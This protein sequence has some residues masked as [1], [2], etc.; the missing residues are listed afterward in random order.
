MDGHEND[1]VKIHG[2][3]FVLLKKFIDGQ[4]SYG[5][6]EQILQ[7]IGRSGILFN[8]K[9]NYPLE[10]FNNI[11]NAAAKLTKVS[12]DEFVEKFGEY[13][14]PDLLIMYAAFLKPHW[15][16]FELLENTEIVMH[17][18]VRMQ[19]KNANPPVL[20]IYRANDNLLI[21]DYYSKRKLACLAI[22]IIRGIA[23]FYQEADIIRIIP[24]SD[25]DDERVQLKV[26]FRRDD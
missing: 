15:K 7:E 17:K 3:L 26:E 10:L 24:A 6:W 2:S 8:E 13:L 14:V 19:Y 1:A 9:Q 21:I 23:I 18:A 5:T 20:H 12:K 16:T 25:P 22:G 4:I 11:A